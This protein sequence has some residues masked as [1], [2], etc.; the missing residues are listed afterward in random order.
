MKFTGVSIDKE[1][2]VS[3]RRIHYLK[4][5][6]KGRTNVS[7]L[8]TRVFQNQG[9]LGNPAGLGGL[10]TTYNDVRWKATV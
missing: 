6:Y 8:R 9:A 3:S 10:E 5:P 4:S 2:S 7:T 1:G